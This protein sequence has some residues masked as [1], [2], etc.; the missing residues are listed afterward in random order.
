MGQRKKQVLEI[1]FSR[2]RGICGGLWVMSALFCLLKAAETLNS[3][4]KMKKLYRVLS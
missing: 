4:F 1:S 3:K 2:E